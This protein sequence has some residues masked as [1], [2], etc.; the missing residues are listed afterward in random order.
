MLTNS[1]PLYWGGLLH[2]LGACCQHHGAVMVEPLYDGRIA[3]L[4][5]CS[6]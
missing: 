3:A 1:H 6:V 5:H 4:L 2:S